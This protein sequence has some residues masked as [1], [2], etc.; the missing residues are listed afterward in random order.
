MYLSYTFKYFLIE[1]ILPI[2]PIPT[3]KIK[4]KVIIKPNISENGNSFICNEYSSGAKESGVRVYNLV[5]NSTELYPQ[6]SF[7]YDGYTNSKK[8]WF[9]SYGWENEHDKWENVS[10]DKFNERKKVFDEYKRFD[11]K[12]LNEF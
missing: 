9:L 8:P 7:K 6:V 3:P 1:I 4:C 11:F 10:E 12:P 5:E 2:E